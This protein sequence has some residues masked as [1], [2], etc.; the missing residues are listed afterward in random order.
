[1]RTIGGMEVKIWQDGNT[2]GTTEEVEE[3][4]VCLE[5]QIPE[6]RKGGECFYVLKTEGW[7]IDGPE[8]LAPLLNEIKEAAQKISEGGE[9]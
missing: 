3:L 9:R 8:E 2:V 5:Y 6:P 1:M 7:S 4:T